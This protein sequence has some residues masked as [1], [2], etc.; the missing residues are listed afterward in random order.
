[1]D[2]H[3]TCHSPLDPDDKP[4]G[5]S[6]LLLTHFIDGESETWRGSMSWQRPLNLK[7]EE[8][9]VE[10]RSSDSSMSTQVIHN[11]ST[12]QNWGEFIMSQV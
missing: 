6:V 3:F 10:T 8:L 4:S 9:G 7:V 2:I 1:M 12:N 11:Q 5:S